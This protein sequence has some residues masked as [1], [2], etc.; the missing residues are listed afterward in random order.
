MYAAPSRSAELVV[1]LDEEIR[2]YDSL[3]A[4]GFEEREAIVGND[5]GTLDALVGRKE[6]LIAQVARIEAQRQAWVMEWA[7]EQ[8]IE[9]KGLTLAALVAQVPGGVASALAER[10]EQLLARVRE[11]GET[12]FQNKQLLSSALNIVSRRLDAYE[13]FSTFSYRPSGHGVKGAST[14]V[15]DYRA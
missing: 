3:L 10:R 7:A 12:S 2:V 8:G 6:A 11:M 9:S 15:L 14:A 1:L 13:R 5:P 4:L